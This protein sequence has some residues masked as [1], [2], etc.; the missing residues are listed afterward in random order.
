[1]R[2]KSFLVISLFFLFFTTFSLNV[3]AEEKK[4]FQIGLCA[5]H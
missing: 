1:M 2:K 5:N 4:D 3:M